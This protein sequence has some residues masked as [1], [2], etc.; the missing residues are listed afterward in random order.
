MKL[1]IEAL[2]TALKEHLY[3]ATQTNTV[4]HITEVERTIATIRIVPQPKPRP[5]FGFMAGTGEISADIVIESSKAR[6]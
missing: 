1:S 2:S 5:A 3:E 6:D 4:I